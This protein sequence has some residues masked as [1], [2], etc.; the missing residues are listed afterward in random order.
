MSPTLRALVLMVTGVLV[1][2]DGCASAPGGAYYA[3]DD[4]QPADI[5]R[6][7]QL[8]NELAGD[9]SVEGVLRYADLTRW[10]RDR[11]RSAYYWYKKA[12]LDGDAV[13]A[14]NL[15]YMYE[16][17]SDRGVDNQEALTFYRLATQ[18]PVGQRQLYALMIKV[19]VDSQRHY[20]EDIEQQGMTLVEFDRGVDGK[21]TEVKVYRTS[22]NAELDAAAVAA[23]RNAELPTV[24]ASLRGEHHFVISVRPG[25]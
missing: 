2:L 6:S 13:A 5:Y 22:G 14:A 8:F 12:A 16:A 19:A 1:F 24:P 4:G 15:W 7:W 11:F 20:P 9:S 10:D 3:T 18:S 21:A 25:P 23:V 17:H